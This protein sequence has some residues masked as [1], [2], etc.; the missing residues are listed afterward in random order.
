MVAAGLSSGAI[1]RRSKSGALHRVHRAVY[2]VGHRALA[3]RAR[4]QAALLACGKGGVIS[5]LS[6]ARLWSLVPDDEDFAEVHVTV[7]GRKLR[8]REGLRVHRT[9]ILDPLDVRRVDGLLVTAPARTL[10]DQAAVNWGG[11]EVAFAEAHAQRLLRSGELEA[12]LDRAGPRRGVRVVRALMDA[13]DSG[14]TRSEAER[15]MRRLVR[16]AQLPEPLFNARVLGHEVDALWPDHK[17]ILEVDGYGVHGHRFA[18]ERDRRRDGE[19]VAAGF[20][21]IRVTW[22]QLVHEPLVVV[23]IVARAL[24]PGAADR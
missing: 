18:F 19:R 22:A 16:T 12:A 5:H 10:L 14:F 17:L 21:V 4:E 15:R 24:G 6:A 11:L 3:P 8:S 13:Y 1:D 20:R 23:G 7:L 2:L 9:T